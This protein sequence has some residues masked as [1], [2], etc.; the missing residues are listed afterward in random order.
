MKEEK[1]PK[2]WITWV[3]SDGIRCEVRVYN[4]LFSVPEPSER[5]EEELNP[6]SEAVHKTAIVDPS[7]VDICDAKHVDKWKSNAAFQFERN[8]YYVV[9]TDTTFNSSDKSG[10]LVFNRTVSLKEEVFKKEISEEEARA[11][12]ERREK[13][14]RDKEAKETR[15]KIPAEDFFRLAP[16][17]KDRFSKFD[18]KGT[19]SHDAK[20]E[21]LT[22]S[23]LKKLEKEK[24]K[25][26]KQLAKFN[27]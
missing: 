11:I 12:E 10:S 9:D 19:P 18:E 22:K 23:A 7:I 15:M 4:N 21:K 25:H 2:S 3:P 17:Y 6:T 27:K 1:K 8:G 24:Q 16:E 5:W 20:G 26:I 13:S 14:K